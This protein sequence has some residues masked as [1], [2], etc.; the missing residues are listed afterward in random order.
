MKRI[1]AL[2]IVAV[3]IAT[4]AGFAVGRSARGTTAPVPIQSSR[5][6]TAATEIAALRATASD[7]RESL[8]ETYF[9]GMYS[10]HASFL[11]REPAGDIKLKGDGNGV[12]FVALLSAV[13]TDPL[14][15]TVDVWSS[16]VPADGSPPKWRNRV[17]HQ[18]TLPVRDGLISVLLP[19]GANAAMP[20]GT[21]RTREG[22]F[23]FGETMM[24]FRE[25]ASAAAR[26]PELLS[27]PFS[28][29]ADPD[30]VYQLFS[31]PK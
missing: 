1:W 20:Y 27:G 29:T 18:Q 7:L 12:G 21:E 8:S 23:D 3:V 10:D 22:D 15:V 16:Y 17:R 9:D 5:E 2:V 26:N 24:T 30:G 28:V 31:T 19:D 13:S 11:E 6:S 4:A 25:F 14:S